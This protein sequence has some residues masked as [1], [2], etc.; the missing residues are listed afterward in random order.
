MTR[1]FLVMS[2]VAEL[3]LFFA[4]AAALGAGLLYLR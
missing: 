2:N 3:S 4:A 1:L